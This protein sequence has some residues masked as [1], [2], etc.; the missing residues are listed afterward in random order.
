LHELAATRG[1]LEVAIEA[2]GGAGARRIL[3]IDLVVG[4]LAGMLDDSV[5]FYF[6]ILSRGT[7]ADGAR[8]RFR[9]VRPVVHCLSCGERAG[10]APPLPQQCGRCG[11]GE[12]RV[13]GGREFQVASIEV[14]DEGTGGAGDPAGE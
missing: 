4:E 1:V 2:A 13:A 9:R 6:D 8:L 7:A 5:Q 14:D 10:V 12:L 11:S 3:A